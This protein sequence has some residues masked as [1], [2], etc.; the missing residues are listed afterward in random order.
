VNHLGFYQLREQP[1][2]I[3]VDNRFYFNS[4]QHAEALLRLKYAVEHRK[5]LAVIVGSVGTGKTTLARRMLDELDEDQYESALLVVI[6]AS[7]TSEWVLRKI[8]IQLGVKN[9]SEAKADLLSQLYTRLVDIYE[10]GKKAVV[11][12]DEAQMLHDKEIMEEFRGILN[13]E[14]NSEKLITFIFF[15]LS[16]LDETMSL[17]KPLQQRI[18][19]RY[20][21]R[22]FSEE[23][24]REYIQCRLEIAGAR[25]PLF[26]GKSLSAIHY[27]S[28]GIPRLINTI[29]DNALFEGFLIKRELID[30][31]MIQEIAN[32]LNLT[33]V[34]VQK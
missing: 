33:S 34:P 29:C 18:A 30:E 32:D 27:Y 10:S 11:L 28:K 31:K 13:I 23:V 25:S 17:D 14:Y 15:G 4:Q 5:G 26:S 7:I 22:S 16:E 3:S 6:H 8:A 21:L 24:T 9:P 12:V 1:F 2:S 19:I 20:P